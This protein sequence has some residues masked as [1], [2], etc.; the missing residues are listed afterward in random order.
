MAEK[1]DV[2]VIGGGPAGISAAL[3]LRHRNKTV[4]VV[5]NPPETTNLWKAKEIGN[6]PGITGPGKIGR[7]HV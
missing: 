1:Y 3:T 5:G 2:I 4:A 7:A 6:Y